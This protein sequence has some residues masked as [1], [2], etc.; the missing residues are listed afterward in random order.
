MLNLRFLAWRNKMILNKVYINNP[1]NHCNIKHCTKEDKNVFKC[2]VHI[3]TVL[4]GTNLDFNI[5]CKKGAFI[6]EKGS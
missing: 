6:Q 5:V 3:G 2:L 4:K 1:A